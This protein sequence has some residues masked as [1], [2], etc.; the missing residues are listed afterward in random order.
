MSFP[1]P[2]RRQWRFILIT[3]FVIYT[4]GYIAVRETRLLVHR[5]GYESRDTG[6][7]YYH[8]VDEGDFGPVLIF[9]ER[10]TVDMLLHA[11]DLAYWTFTPWRWLEIVIWHIVPRTYEFR[12]PPPNK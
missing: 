9:H 3:L 1:H 2:T 6:L 5:V 11:R 12:N 8:Y 10:S 7:R 4:I